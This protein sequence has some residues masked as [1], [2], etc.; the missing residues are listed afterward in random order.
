MQAESSCHGLVPAL[1][2]R[3]DLP[4]VFTSIGRLCLD[5]L[6]LQ[7]EIASDGGGIGRD[8]SHVET[9]F[10]SFPSL[11]STQALPRMSRVSSHSGTSRA[12]PEAQ[13][14]KME[15]YFPAA[16]VAFSTL[17]MAL[18]C[19]SPPNSTFIDLARSK[20]PMKITSETTRVSKI[21]AVGGERQTERGRGL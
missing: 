8:G 12:L 1:L 3:V 21:K 14:T 13:R 4:G 9:L 5:S 20:G 18:S 6:E 2:P 19:C 7:C 17:A 11:L 15:A 16:L 10:E